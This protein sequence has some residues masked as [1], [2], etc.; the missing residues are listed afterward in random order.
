MY[1]RQPCVRQSA[2][3]AKPAISLT[4][5]NSSSAST[6]SQASFITSKSLSYDRAGSAIRATPH[7]RPDPKPRETASTRGKW[8]MKALCSIG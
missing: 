1:K 6:A 8:R 2:K 4:K 7:L 5:A 3:A